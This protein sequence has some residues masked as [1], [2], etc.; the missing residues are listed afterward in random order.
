VGAHIHGPAAAAAMPAS[1]S[2]LRQV[3]ANPLMG[4]ATLTDDQATG[5]AGREDYV[6]FHTTRIP[7]AKYAARLRPK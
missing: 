2:T 7:A 3:V 6:N 1:S 5:P 4:S